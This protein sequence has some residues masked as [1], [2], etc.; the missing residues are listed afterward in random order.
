MW[1][2]TVVLIGWNWV[3]QHHAMYWMVMLK[4]QNLCPAFSSMYFV[5]IFCKCIDLYKYKPICQCYASVVFVIHEGFYRTPAKSSAILSSV[6]CTSMMP[7]IFQC[8]NVKFESV[9]HFP[10]FSAEAK[11]ISQV[12]S[13]KY[14]CF[15]PNANIYQ[16]NATIYQHHASIMK[17]T[18]S[19]P[20]HF[21]AQCQHDASMS[22]IMP[23]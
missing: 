12:K 2:C 3:I 23:A 16:Q 14:H 9:H 17:K 13:S 8:Q 10:P 21:P 4:W 15:Q 20:H 18:K 6:W 19:L 7:A 22:S 5:N 1:S 11:S